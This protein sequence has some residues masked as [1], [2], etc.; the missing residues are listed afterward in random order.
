MKP[1]KPKTS[2]ASATL[3][4]KEDL[5]AVLGNIVFTYVVRMH[6]SR[7]V[8]CAPRLATGERADGV[9]HFPP[10]EERCSPTCL[11]QPSQS[12]QA[13]PDVPPGLP[14]PGGD[15]SGQQ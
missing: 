15:V 3:P 10:G 6:S 2:E 11:C 4:H 12:H 14:S 1:E 5:L 7:R 13:G 8:P 9:Y